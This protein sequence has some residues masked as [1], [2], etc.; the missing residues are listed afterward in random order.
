MSIFFLFVIILIFTST[1]V[2]GNS[3]DEQA[4]KDAWLW[5]LTWF[6]FFY[7]QCV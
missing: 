3:F 7:E 6:T 2:L 5:I 1:Q 4:K